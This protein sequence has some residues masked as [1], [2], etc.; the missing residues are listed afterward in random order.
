MLFWYLLVLAVTLVNVR[1]CKNGFFPD[2]MD[3]MQSNAIKGLFIMLVFLGHALI[4][5]RDC[6]FSFDH[7]I[8]D[9]AKRIYSELGQLVVAIFLF[10][11]GYGV[12]RSFLTKGDDY[13]ASYPKRRL[14]TTLLNFDVAVCFFIL[15]WVFLGKPLNFSRVL[16]SFIG[17]EEMGNSNW[18]IFII[19]CCY[20]LFYM[21]F[22][23][24]HTRHLLGSMLITT[25]LFMGM[26]ALH[27]V[28]QSNWYNTILVFPAGIFYALYLK[29]L[30]RFI[31]KRYWFS[32]VFLLTVLLLLHFGHFRLLHGLTFN[33]KAIIFAM[34]LVS[35]SMKVRICNKWLVW[36]GVSLFPL[37]IYQRLPMNAIRGWI[38]DDWVSSNPNLYIGICFAVTVG[39]AFLY[40]KF[41]RIQFK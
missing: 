19:L 30:E 14:L 13:L 2:Y 33:L 23:L 37:Y 3:K 40:N 9:A 4:S 6:G 31:Q 39:I 34:L 32:I 18:Y 25:M 7:W 22:R 10:Y 20:L 28:K 11:S 35:L 26:L 8:D 21:V 17:W 29:P 38:G 16:L 27:S 12:M 41:I 15:L 36:C 5:V 24:A 1:V